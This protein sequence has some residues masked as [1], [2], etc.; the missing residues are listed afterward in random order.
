MTRPNWTLR[1]RT[2]NDKSSIFYPVR[3][4][5]KYGGTDSHSY[6]LPVNHIS[7]GVYR[8]AETAWPLP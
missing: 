5:M 3:N 8:L 4:P 1:Y 6:K 7:N 2:K